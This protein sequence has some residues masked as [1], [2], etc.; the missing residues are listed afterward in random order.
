MKN[1]KTLLLLFL[2]IPLFICCEKYEPQ[3]GE[4]GDSEP[5]TEIVKECVE[6]DGLLFDGILYY[7]IINQIEATVYCVE[8]DL[9]VGD[10]EIPHKIKLGEDVFTVTHIGEFAFDGCEEIINIKI[11]NTITYIGEE[12]FECCEKLIE[13]IIPNSVTYIGEEAFAGCYGF[14]RFV[15]LA[16]TP[17]TIHEDTFDEVSCPLYVPKGALSNYKNHP[18]WGKFI[19]INE[20]NF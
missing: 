11:P 6:Q 9:C 20:V 10:I 16:T 5:E 8:E 7:E 13:I 17:P 19:N 4:G 14:S 12:A 3:N 18:I 15:C 1:L 2:A